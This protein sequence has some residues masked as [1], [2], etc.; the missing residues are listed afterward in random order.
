MRAFPNVTVSDE[1]SFN[2]RD[3]LIFRLSPELGGLTK[4]TAYSRLSKVGWN[5]IDF[6]FEAFV[7]R[8]PELGHVVFV[9]LHTKEA[10]IKKTLGIPKLFSRKEFEAYVFSLQEE[11]L[12]QKARI[13]NETNILIHDLR[14]L[15][16]SIYHAA[17]AARDDLVSGNLSQTQDRI[18]NVIAAQGMLRIRTDVLDFAGNPNLLVPPSSI[19][20]YKRVHKVVRSF[21]PYAEGRNIS[22]RMRGNSRGTSLG[23]D[24]FEIIPYVIIDNAIK[25]SPRNSTVE[26]S[27]YENRQMI[28]VAVTSLG[29]VIA[30]DEEE[31]IFDEHFRGRAAKERDLTGNGVGLFLAKKLVEQFNGRIKVKQELASIPT[32][33]GIC[34]DTTFLV[35][36]PKAYN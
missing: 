23:P 29:P 25:Y 14:R 36:V 12:Q 31:R 16:Q 28:D 4:L 6:G 17:V 2:F 22:I 21:T 34:R 20:I 11:V 33:K 35:T 18:E 27:V 24:A 8:S 26:V 10:K 3:G 9:G 19:P 32:E 7:H 15:S 13:Q 1:G 5:V 30:S